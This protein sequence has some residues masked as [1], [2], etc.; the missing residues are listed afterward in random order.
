MFE[1]IT[2]EMKHLPSKPAL[3]IVISTAAQIALVGALLVPLLFFT[4]HLP[5]TPT[6]LA[7]VSAPPPPP[8][9]PPPPAPAEKKPVAPE[10]K[11]VPT[12][13]GAPIEPPAEIT[14]ERPNDEGDLGVPGGVEGG[15]PGG[16]IGGVLGGLP[17]DIPPPPPPPAPVRR[18][19]VRV[20]GQIREP[21]IVRRVEPVYPQLA[22]HANVTGTVILEAIVDTDGR[23]IN[24]KV[25]RSA[26]R[27]LDDAALAAV[28]QW[29]YTPVILNGIPEQ[30][31]L[32]VV[33]SFNLTDAS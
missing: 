17:A 10:T 6:M 32:T 22:V 26:H 25:L 4:G 30:F 28:R 20:G 33:L 16:V 24:V 11:P 15:I 7:F 27:L 14:P 21:S 29:Q 5:E 1:L 19:P 13:G 23:V 31:I 18:A 12:S 3:P 8:P 9:P 2:G